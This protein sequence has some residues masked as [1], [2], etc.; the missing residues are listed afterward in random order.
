MTDPV[1]GPLLGSQ[2]ATLER[3]V[4]R[5]ALAGEGFEWQ[6]VN[7]GW[8]GTYGV[9]LPAFVH[10][11]SGSLFS[12]D[13]REPSLD[14]M[15]RRTA[16]QFIFHRVPGIEARSETGAVK[17]WDAVVAEFELWLRLLAR[18]LGREDVPAPRSTA[19]APHSAFAFVWP[20]LHEEI[21]ELGRP[22]F[23][24]GQYAD[25][26]EAALKHVNAVVKARV[27]GLLK[28]DLDGAS[29]MKHVFS[30]DKPILLFGD[31][32]TQTGRA[33]QVGYMELFSGAMSG[34]RNPK[35]H[36]NLNIDAIRAIH[37]LFLASLLRSKIDETTVV[38]PETDTADPSGDSGGGS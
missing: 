3:I 20:L 4:A 7:A 37:F 32:D 2:I 23:D 10:L 30:A 16:G 28:R 8:A 33:M 9:D 34:V 21:R 22:R 1:Q 19:E 36:E 31:T 35:A 29:L 17:N 15:G 5:S 27:R 25:S 38:P 11:G 24:A 18:E 14:R 13:Y 6:Q 26:A 12:I